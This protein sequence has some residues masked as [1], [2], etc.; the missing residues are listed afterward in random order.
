MLTKSYKICN[1]PFGNAPRSVLIVAG[2]V[3]YL[4]G[5]NL[6]KNIKEKAA[7]FPL[8][9]GRDSILYIS[10]IGSIL[11]NNFPFKTIGAYIF[12]VIEQPYEVRIIKTSY[13]SIP[14]LILIY[15]Y[16]ILKF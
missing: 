2:Y 10:I 9:L 6:F 13:L 12:L 8:N 1:I 3:L 5:Q 14:N 4:E 11:I 16:R 7:N 15:Y